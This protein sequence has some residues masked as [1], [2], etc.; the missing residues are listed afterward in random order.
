M[1]KEPFMTCE[2]TVENDKPLDNGD[3]SSCI[4]ETEP[5]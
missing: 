3:I 4:E 2:D 1:S 5:D